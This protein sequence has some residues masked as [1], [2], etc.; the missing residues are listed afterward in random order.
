[1]KIAVTDSGVGGL[2]V[3]GALEAGLRRSGL[4]RDVELLYLNA[5]W[6]D[7]YAYNSMPSR[8]VKLEAFD[9]FL[10]S[11]AERF[12]PELLFIACNSLSVL[13]P[14]T[15]FATGR[16]LPVTGIVEAGVQSMLDELEAAPDSAVVVLATPTTVEEGVYGRELRAA[17]VRPGR[18]SEQACPGLADAISNDHS[19]GQASAL[20][21][22][23]LPAALSRLHGDFGAVI[24]Y[25]GCTHYGYQ[26][27]LFRSSLRR[28]VSTVRVVNPN[29][30]A[31]DRVL[32][33]LQL[34]PGS[35]RLDVRVLSRYVIPERPLASLSHYLGQFAPATLAALLESELEPGLCGPPE[36]LRAMI[37]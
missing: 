18:I 12:A 27:D 28:F 31:A 8:A 7:E 29:P 6:E 16:R 35:G 19:G 34:G 24:L 3:C 10:E 21:E 15:T 1:M 4:N 17:G 5:A 25:L 2:S 26:A 33:A 14:F 37:A 22:E 13:Y 23:F 30:A 11:V 32:S 20:L 36:R 9:L